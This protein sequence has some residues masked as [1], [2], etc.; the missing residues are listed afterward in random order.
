MKRLVLALLAVCGTAAFAP[1][2]A[3]SA[4]R[5]QPRDRV[6]CSTHPA[7]SRRRYSRNLLIDDNVDH[8]HCPLMTRE[9]G[10]DSC[11]WLD[12]FPWCWLRAMHPPRRDL[13]AAILRLAASK[14]KRS[15]RSAPRPWDLLACVALTRGWSL[16]ASQMEKGPIVRLDG[17]VSYREMQAGR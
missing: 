11:F 4:L 6:V 14:D 9:G 2:P 15:L 16:Q 17:G 1:P 10:A 3:D 7:D 12:P 13:L 8:R 5:F